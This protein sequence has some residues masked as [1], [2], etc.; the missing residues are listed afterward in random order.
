MGI[1]LEPWLAKLDALTYAQLANVQTVGIGLYLALAVIQAVSAGGV[2]SLR[3]RADTLDAGIKSSRKP[4]LEVESSA[5][6]ADLGRL[7]MGFE[8]VNRTILITVLCLFIV[9]IVYFAFCTIW[10]DATA[11]L[12]GSLF[13]MCF[14]LGLPVVIFLAAA[15][16]IS[17]RCR[18]IDCRIRKLQRTYFSA[19]LGG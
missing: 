16:H 4:S 7:E 8:R 14:Y 9:S 6:L 3:R 5:I 12:D 11:H 15:K 17:W 2:A 19:V 13:I 1:D 10:Q 18:E